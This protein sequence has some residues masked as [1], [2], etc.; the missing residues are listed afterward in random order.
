MTIV[1]MNKNMIIMKIITMKKVMKNMKVIKMKI[2]LKLNLMMIIKQN[3]K[4]KFISEEI[5]DNNIENHNDNNMGNENNNEILNEESQNKDEKI[6]RKR[7]LN[8]I[9][10]IRLKIMVR[11]KTKKLKKKWG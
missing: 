5:K 3:H 11:K 9:K 8:R 7:K 10:K 4:D 1:K 2:L 6:L